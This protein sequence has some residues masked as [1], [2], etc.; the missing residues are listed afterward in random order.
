M[1]NFLQF[2]SS[3][4]LA[5]KLHALNESRPQAYLSVV[6]GFTVLG[7]LLISLLP[8]VL[9]V[10]ILKITNN[11]GEATTWADWS[12]LLIWLAIGIGTGFMTYLMLR[13]RV[14]SPRGLGLKTD[15]APQLYDLLD[16][17]QQVFKHPKIHR[18]VLHDQ[19]NLDFI[20]VPRFG[21]PLLTLNVLYIG[22]PILQSL[23]PAQFRALLARKLGQYSMAHNRMTH[24]VYRFRQYA[25]LYQHAYQKQSRDQWFYLPFKWF[26]QLFVPLINTITIHAIRMDELEADNY[27]REIMNDDEFADTL[28]RH[29]VVKHFLQEKFYP[30]IQNLLE[31]NPQQPEF[32][33][34]R[35][36]AKVL[37][38][39]LTDHEVATTLETLIKQEPTWDA[40]LPG[41]HTRLENMSYRNLTLPP[42]VLDNAAH[43]LLGASYAPVVKLMD[44]QWLAK[45]GIAPKKNEPLTKKSEEP[46][47]PDQELFR[48]LSQQAKQTNLDD[49]R[50][51]QLA[52]LTEKYSGKVAA[53]GLYQQILKRNAAHGKTW[54]AI[55]RILLSQQDAT[56]VKALERAMELDTLCSGQACWML[57]K[58]FRAQ[59]NEALAKQYIERAAHSS[60]SS[61]A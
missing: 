34:H 19:F 56:G 52:K 53:I 39:G 55:G 46:V 2:F 10:S 12:A 18:V 32:L 5:E 16:E 14:S 48:Q 38:T 60:A 4:G 23:S 15:K 45:Q 41:L 58:Y 57:A 51:W 28:I 20:P 25:T 22:L 9:L 8:L 26:F 36:M 43:R 54:F 13:L 6:V 24:W 21:L 31:K 50:L 27:G 29:E 40:P 30:K 49:D 7:Y 3:E 11:I 42:P 17:L 35:S 1:N 37:R 33:P 47:E 59:G 61:A 44:Q